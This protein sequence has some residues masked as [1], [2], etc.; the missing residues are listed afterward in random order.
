[1]MMKTTGKNEEAEEML[2]RNVLLSK[3]ATRMEG[4]LAKNGTLS[5]GD[6]SECCNQ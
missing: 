6:L 1:M 2:S 3:H 4:D 5:N